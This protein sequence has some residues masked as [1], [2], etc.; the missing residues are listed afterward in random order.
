V[1]EPVAP[2][3]EDPTAPAELATCTVTC[4]DIFAAGS[5]VRLPLLLVEWA[6][7]SDGSTRAQSVRQS[8]QDS[9]RLSRSTRSA[10]LASLAHWNSNSPALH[11][12]YPVLSAALCCCCCCCC[13]VRGTKTARKT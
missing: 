12:A 13:C 2:G 5:T 6:V 11:S 9:T 10:M 8:A 3:V 1:A 7:M 4:C